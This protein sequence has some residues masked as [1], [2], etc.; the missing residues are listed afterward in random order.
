LLRYF[1]KQA[2]K[3]W[4]GGNQMAVAATMTHC[5]VSPPPPPP[6]FEGAA[7]LNIA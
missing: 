3:I 2:F 5:P 1:R 7:I 4:F 6:V